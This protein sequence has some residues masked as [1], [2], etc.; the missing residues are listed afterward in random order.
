MDAWMKELL[1]GGWP[2]DAGGG[3]SSKPP[4]SKRAPDAFTFDVGAAH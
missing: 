3:S 2:L 4:A 1:A